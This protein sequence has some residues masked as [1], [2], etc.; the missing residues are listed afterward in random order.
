MLQSDKEFIYILSMPQAFCEEKFKGNKLVNLLKDTL[1]QHS[2]QDV[3]WVLL[4][5]F[6]KIYSENEEHNTE[7]KDLKVHHVTRKGAH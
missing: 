3:A 7:Q 1:N 5:T 2:I 6:S 4:A